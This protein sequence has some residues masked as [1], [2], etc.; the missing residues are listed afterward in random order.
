MIQDITELNIK[1]FYFNSSSSQEIR[2]IVD[3]KINFTIYKV[4]SSNSN[5]YIKQDI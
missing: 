2:K 5:I 4:T 1:I 3:S